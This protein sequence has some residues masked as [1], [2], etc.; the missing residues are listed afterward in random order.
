MKRVLFAL[1]RRLLRMAAVICPAE[2]SEWIEAVLAEAESVEGPWEAL[3]WAWGAVFFACRCRILVGLGIVRENIMMSRGSVAYIVVFLVVVGLLLA[4]PSFRDA[5]AMGPTMFKIVFGQRGM[6]E[7]ELQR[8]AAKAQQRGDASTMAFVAMNLEDS[9]RGMQLGEKA[10]ALNPSLVWIKYFIIKRDWRTDT[11]RATFGQE[12]HEV[13]AADPDNALGY[14]LLASWLRRTDPSLA[15]RRAEWEAAMEKAFSAQTYDDYLNRRLQLER[16]VAREGKLSP[17]E[18]A[19]SMLYWPIPEVSEVTRY[20]DQ[21]I[22]SGDIQECARVARFGAMMESG[23]SRFDRFYGQS[24]RES[25]LGAIEKKLN[26][27][28]AAPK[29]LPASP[30]DWLYSEA[31]LHFVLLDGIVVQASF[32]IGSL[33]GMLVAVCA[34]TLFLGRRKSAMLERVL[35]NAAITGVAATLA[36]F[37]AYL[38]FA[39]AYSSILHAQT[40]REAYAAGRSI[41][42][43]YSLSFELYVFFRT[44]GDV[45]LWSLVILLG[46]ALVLWRFVVFAQRVRMKPA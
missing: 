32:L 16:G 45:Y 12:V 31:L 44:Q 6:S 26:L 11:R 4:T 22:A 23:Q 35:R 27:S 8:M 40:A 17:F 28:L 25:A 7:G 46:V 36:A 24:L 18:T 15:T 41:I 1:T 13:I 20:K 14:M 37:L 5:A 38:P 19:W 29:A 30:E 34:V 10:I 39:F 3:R 43:F 21:L 42:V 33:A 2:K 9:E